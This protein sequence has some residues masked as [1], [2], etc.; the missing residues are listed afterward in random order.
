MSTT[1]AKH[2]TLEEFMRLPDPADGSKQELVQGE[3]VTMPPPSFKHGRTQT[4]IAVFLEMFGEQNQLGQVTTESGLVTLRGPDSVRGPD[5]AFWS[6]KRLPLNADVKGYA[7]IAADLCVEVVSENKRKREI[8]RKL[9]EYFTAG[10]RMVW[11]VDTENRTVTVYRSP[12][13]G[14]VLPEEAQIDG[15]DV[16]P[17]FSCPVAK[18]FP[19]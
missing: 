4:K 8:K 19:Y 3:I 2:Y 15:E 10:V 11:V 7:D 12:T 13:Q 17:G 14:K 6:A 5:V 9:S 18:F 1:A 16:L